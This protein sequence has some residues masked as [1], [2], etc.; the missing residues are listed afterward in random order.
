MKRVFAK[1]VTVVIL[2]LAMLS[3]FSCKH[4]DVKQIMV[5]N[6]FALSLFRDSIYMDELFDKMDSSTVNWLRVNEDGTL[7]AFYHDSIK[8]LV[9]AHDFLSN[10]QDVD[11]DESGTFHVNTV[12]PQPEPGMVQV[13]LRDW[14][15][16]A[17]VVRFSLLKRH[18]QRGRVQN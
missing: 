11:F 18:S 16:Q 15:G 1:T 7:S 13:L 10:V 6:E 8:G 12:A 4:K 2:F 3:A 9:N 5:H 17:L 14:P